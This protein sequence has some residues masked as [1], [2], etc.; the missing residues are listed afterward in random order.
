MLAD[1]GAE[2]AATEAADAGTAGALPAT[3]AEAVAEAS[4]TADAPAAGSLS[5]FLLHAVA[6]ATAAA[7]VTA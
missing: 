1:T 4:G 3:L 7:M 5:L 6:I 2:A